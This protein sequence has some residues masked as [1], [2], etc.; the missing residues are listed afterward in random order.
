MF[1][2]SSACRQLTLLVALVPLQSMAQDASTPERIVEGF[3][4]WEVRCERIDPGVTTGL[5]ACEMV[6]ATA[7]QGQD[8]PITQIAIGRPTPDAALTAVIQLPLGM[9][10]PSGAV[11]D[12]GE[13]GGPHAISILRCLPNGC[14]GELPLTDVMRA[15]LS[16]ASLTGSALQFEMQAGTPA[17]VPVVHQGF[18]AAIASLEARLAP[19]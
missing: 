8:Q 18:S 5:L 16:D 11:L 17:R 3:G 4:A 2:F 1:I 9:W 15:T 6:Q 14:L 10:L 19:E 12:L 7:M 13:G